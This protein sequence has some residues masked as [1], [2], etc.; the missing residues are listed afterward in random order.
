MHAN[1]LTLRIFDAQAANQPFPFLFFAACSHSFPSF[2]VLPSPVHFHHHPP[3]HRHHQFQQ[4]GTTPN[5]RAAYLVDPVDGFALTKGK[6]GY[7][8][9]TMLLRD[10][11]MK[12][13]ITGVCVLLCY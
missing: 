4:T 7:P 10:R 6:I 9:A 13:G 1:L 11:N 5:V 3:A 8:S 12:L 2:P